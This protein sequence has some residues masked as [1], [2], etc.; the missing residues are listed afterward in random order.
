M[1]TTKEKEKQKS[2]AKAIDLRKRKAL[3]ELFRYLTRI[4]LSY[5]KGLTKGL[6][7]ALVTAM[8]V[9]PLD[10]Q[11][12]CKTPVRELWTGCQPYFYRCIAR[13]AQVTFSIFF[14]MSASLNSMCICRFQGHQA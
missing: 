13:H 7:S 11:A 2:E 12:G 4:G 14:S 10:L 6:E 1:D 3:S 5:R 8:E 9:A